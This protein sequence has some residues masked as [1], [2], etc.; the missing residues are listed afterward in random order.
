[1]LVFVARRVALAAVV[2]AGV[3]MLTFVV[4]HVVPGDPAATWAGPHASP[5]QIAA[6]RKFL[7]L[8]RPLIVQL[9]TYLGGIL[10]G[11]WGVSIHTHRPVLSDL[12][13]VA[14]AS[15]EL[16]ITALMLAI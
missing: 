2:V 1:M 3:I 4:A 7:G 13:T 14:P 11:N 12:L 6:A 8:N 16:V 15:L 5:A 9:V 10:Q